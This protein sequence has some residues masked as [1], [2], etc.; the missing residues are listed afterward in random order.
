MTNVRMTNDE[1]RASAVMHLFH[2]LAIRPRGIGISAPLRHSNLI[3]NS[4]FV[5]RHSRTTLLLAVVLLAIGCSTPSKVNIELRKQIQKQDDELREARKQVE[6]DKRVIAGLRD[7]MGVLPTLPSSRLDQLF[8]THGL[9]F[10]RLTGGADLDPNKPGDEGLAIYVVPTDQTGQPLK[11]AGAFDVE[12][13]DLANPSDPLV[14]HWHFNLQQSKETW[15]GMSLIYCYALI[16]PWQK[17]P[18]HEDL[19]VKVTFFDELTQTPFSAQK[20]VHVMLPSQATT[21]PK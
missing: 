14:G 1:T 8:T 4:N 11:A 12:A 19:T 9:E 5:I 15:N 6:A 13:F 10:T 3:R 21:R 7:R 18:K 20:L 17:V 16:C 2:H